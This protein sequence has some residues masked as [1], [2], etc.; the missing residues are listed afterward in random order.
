[1][2]ASPPPIPSIPHAGVGVLEGDNS[3]TLPWRKFFQ[4]LSTIANSVPTPADL[5]ALKALAEEALATANTALTDAEAALAAAMNAQTGLTPLTVLS[6]AAL[7]GSIPAFE[8]AK[9]T[10]ARTFTYT[11]DAAG[12]PTSVDGTADVSIA[13]TLAAVNANVGSFG[14]GTDV[15][16]FTVNGK[17]LITAASNV[18]ITS[19]P[20]WTTARTFSYTGDATGGPTS[21]DGSANAST[22]LTLATVNANVGSF[23]NGSHVGAF[24]VNAKGQITAASNVAIGTTAAV[25]TT[26][27]TVTTLATI[28]CAA[29]TTTM[30]LATVVAR[31]TGGGSGAA[32]DSGSFQVAAGFKNVAGAATLVSQTVIFAAKDQAGWAVTFTGSGANALMQVTGAAAN[33]VDWSTNYQTYTVT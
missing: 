26:D 24:T 15:A 12:G 18:P 33:N 20:K 28:A 13:L 9:W 7:D 29:A 4:Y 1:M 27:A 22:A 16:A 19:A 5:A 2:S 11:G 23:G 21:V 14:D 25:S 10:T 32:E 3:L 17:G 30:I 31:R 8:A 6:L